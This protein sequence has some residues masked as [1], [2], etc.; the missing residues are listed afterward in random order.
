[1]GQDTHGKCVCFDSDVQLQYRAG[2]HLDTIMAN[3]LRA[4]IF[5]AH[6]RYHPSLPPSSLPTVLQRSRR[7]STFLHHSC[8]RCV[9]PRH[10]GI[11]VICVCVWES[12]QAPWRSWWGVWSE[13]QPPGQAGWSHSPHLPKKTNKQTAV[14]QQINNSVPRLCWICKKSLIKLSTGFLILLHTDF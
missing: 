4:M 1:M 13:T 6:L 14:A 9:Y 8:A 5:T 10:G 11:Y 7:Y 2:I 3:H 12:E